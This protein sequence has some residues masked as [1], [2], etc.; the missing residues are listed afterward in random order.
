M[1]HPSNEVK[2]LMARAATMLGR[3][4]ELSASGPSAEL[5]RA[6]LPALVNGT[7]EKNTYVRANAEIA[8]RAVL[9]LPQ[10][11][12]FHLVS[13]RNTSLLL[14]YYSLNAI[15][16]CTVGIMVDLLLFGYLTQQVFV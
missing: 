9:R 4:A 10:D 11:E 14:F 7:K 16:N 6:L 8:L 12:Q 5:L 13:T 1:N 15:L 3:E 2:Q